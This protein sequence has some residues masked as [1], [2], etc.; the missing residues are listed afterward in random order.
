MG[1]DIAPR[2]ES[3]DDTPDLFSAAMSMDPT[4][5]IFK[6]EDQWVDNEFNN[7][8]RSYNNQEWNPALVLGSAKIPTPVKW[9]QL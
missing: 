8:Q 4:T 7:Y 2:V 6:P 9:V 5:P 3:W 1:F